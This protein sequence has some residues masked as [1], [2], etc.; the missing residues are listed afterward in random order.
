MFTTG[1]AAQKLT[2]YTPAVPT[3]FDRDDRI[4]FAALERLCDR[5]IYNGA[6]GL[7]VCGTT[8]EAPTLT[9]S[10]HVEIIKIARGIARGRIPVVA[11]IGSNATSDAVELAQDAEVAGADALLCV[12]PYYNKPTQIGMIEHFRAV[13]RSTGLPLILYDI[14]SRCACGL[15]DDTIVRLAENARIIG[16]KDATGDLPRVPRL[17]T[18]LGPHFRLLS[19]DDATALGFIAYGGN[20]CISVT[21]NIAPGLC[22]DM[23]LA[24]RHG[25]FARAQ[26]LESALTPLTAALF[27]ESNPSP[28]KY[29]L[30]LLGVI[31]PSVRLPLVEPTEATKAELAAVIAQLCNCHADELIERGGVVT[32]GGFRAA[33]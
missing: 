3:P 2:G 6:H 18:R 28:L 5:L 9:A 11:G 15:A 19:G 32:P 23:F 1:L 22:R 33:G 4:D 27:R 25:H 16:L 8:G 13:S 30:H 24:Y 26:R 20:G 21:A 7:V 12:V 29:A 31:S 17:R 14:P 10:E